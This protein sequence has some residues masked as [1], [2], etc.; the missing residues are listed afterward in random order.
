[1][2]AS[3]SFIEDFFSILAYLWVVGEMPEEGMCVREESS[4]VLYSGLA[5]KRFLGFFNIF[6]GYFNAFKDSL[7]GNYILL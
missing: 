5:V 3:L 2:F 1:M 7:K 6:L 4:A